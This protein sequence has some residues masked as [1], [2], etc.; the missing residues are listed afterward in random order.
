MFALHA[1]AF[2]SLI[3][4]YAEVVA[5][6]ICICTT[7]DSSVVDPHSSVGLGVSYPVPP[8]ITTPSTKS[9]RVTPDATIDSQITLVRKG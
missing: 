5:S 7:N 4:D 9:L 2:P 1:A 6:C 8:P 3:V